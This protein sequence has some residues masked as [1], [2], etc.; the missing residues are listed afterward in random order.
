VNERWLLVMTSAA[1][2]SHNIFPGAFND[3]DL[4]F[5]GSER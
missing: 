4:I 2:Y 5:L 1:V 3:D